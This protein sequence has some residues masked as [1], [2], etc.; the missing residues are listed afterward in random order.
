[1]KTISI[2]IG[3]IVLVSVVAFITNYSIE[4]VSRKLDV[5]FWECMRKNITHEN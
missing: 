1:M 4:D 3:I 2:I 5:F